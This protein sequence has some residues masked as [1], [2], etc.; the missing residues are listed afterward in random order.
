MWPINFKEFPNSKEARIVNMADDH[1]ALKE[2]L[3]FKSYKA[4]RAKKDE[5]F[6]S[7]LF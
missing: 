6:I 1:I 7:K 2:S 5:E 3:T 4:K